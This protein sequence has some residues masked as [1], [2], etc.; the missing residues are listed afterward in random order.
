MQEKQA[1]RNT[2]TDT[3]FDQ[4]NKTHSDHRD[5]K[6]TKHTDTHTKSGCNSFKAKAEHKKHQVKFGPVTV[7]TNRG[8]LCNNRGEV[9]LEVSL[10]SKR[11][12]IWVPRW[13][14]EKEPVQHPDKTGR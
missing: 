11:Y 8:V 12:R 1:W 13:G 9:F 2:T 6:K 3:R 5:K 14:K 10:N 7:L 4:H